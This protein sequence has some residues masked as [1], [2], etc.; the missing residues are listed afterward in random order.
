LIA[1]MLLGAITFANPAAVSYPLILGGI[2]IIASIIGTYFVKLGSSGKIMG[3]LYKGLIV[4]AVIACI[5]FYFVTVQMFPQGLTNAAGVTY[6]AM[7]VFISAIVGLVVT[8][9]I[10]WIT[11]YYTSTEYGPVKHIAQ[12]STTG[13]GTNVI[14]GLGISMKS[15]ALPVIVISAGIIISF[16]CAGVYGIA[17][18]AVSMLSLTGIVV[19]MYAYAPITDNAG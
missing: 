15:T 13:H 2:S 8:G 4:S 1:A 10:F 16:Q 19:A 14:A 6:S 5:A 11:E 12:A 3:A 18:A 7:S 9:A 17:I